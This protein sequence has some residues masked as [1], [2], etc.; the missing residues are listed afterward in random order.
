M[1]ILQ[2]NWPNI[3][4]MEN[5]QPT[6]TLLTIMFKSVAVEY[7]D[8]IGMVPLTI[9][10]SSILHEL[11]TKVLESITAIGYEVVVN[12]VDGHSSNVKFYKKEFLSKYIIL[13]FPNRLKWHTN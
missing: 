12:L 9:I 8:V 5:N 3:F 13:N 1:R 10:S 11:F 4:G 7:E 6:K 2:I